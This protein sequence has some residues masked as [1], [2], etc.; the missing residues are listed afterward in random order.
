MTISDGEDIL[1]TMHIKSWKANNGQDDEDHDDDY[2]DDDEYDNG[3]CHDGDYLN[4]DDDNG[5]HF[6]VS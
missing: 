5:S 6:S 3:Q 4:D 2:D 1:M